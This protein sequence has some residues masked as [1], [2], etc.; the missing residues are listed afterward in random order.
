MC[1]G[2]LLKGESETL[3]SRRGLFWMSVFKV[4]TEPFRDAL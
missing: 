2:V 1:S 4:V 3:W